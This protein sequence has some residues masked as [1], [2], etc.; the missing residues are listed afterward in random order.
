MMFV[1]KLLNA[2]SVKDV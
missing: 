1:W 2:V